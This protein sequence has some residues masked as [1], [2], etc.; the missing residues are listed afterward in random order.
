[1]AA[2][3]HDMS[4]P[5]LIAVV[6]VDGSGK[7][8]TAKALVRELRGRGLRA[9]Y[10]ENA[11]GRP[12]LNWLAR[13]LGHA[14]AVGWLGADRMQAIEQRVRHLLMRL[15]AAWSRLPGERV[16][17]L[18]R[19]TVCQYA[20][21]RARGSVG[22]EAARRRYEHLPWPDAVAFLDVSPVVARDRL[23]R[24]GKDV[25]DLA[26]LERYDAAYRTLPEWERFTIVDGKRSTAE[27]VG[28]LAALV[29]NRTE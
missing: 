17:V 9:K 27:V 22:E 16:A 18:D 5:R 24:R 12:P 11:G 23:V 3:L 28:D 15:A 4:H 20:V 7:T 8:T 26:W 2:T 29:G 1:M 10:F 6:G 19:W 14:D 25:D 13:R 21:V